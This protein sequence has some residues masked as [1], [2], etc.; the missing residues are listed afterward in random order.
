MVTKWTL[1]V[2]L[3]FDDAVVDV[4]EEMKTLHLFG[5]SLR[6]VKT[7]K[8]DWNSC[9]CHFRDV[10]GPLTVFRERSWGSLWGAAQGRRDQTVV[11]LRD[12]G[13]VVSTPRGGYHRECYQSYT[14]KKSLAMERIAD[15]PGDTTG[16][17]DAESAW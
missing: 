5:A 10:S 12:S 17:D 1:A 2:K 8:L 15:D 16:D 9:L 14:N 3:C 7:P 11:F 4:F 6:P 13:A